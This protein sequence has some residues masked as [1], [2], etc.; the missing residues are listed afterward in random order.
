MSANEFHLM[1]TFHHRETIESTGNLSVSRAKRA[2]EKFEINEG[3]DFP[4]IA[5]QM[6]LS[7][8]LSV[9]KVYDK[10]TLISVGTISRSQ[11]YGAFINEKSLQIT[12]ATIELPYSRLN[13]SIHSFEVIKPYA[14]TLGSQGRLT[15]GKFIDHYFH[16]CSQLHINTASSIPSMNLSICRLLA[17]DKKAFYVPVESDWQTCIDKDH[18][19]KDDCTMVI[20]IPAEAIDILTLQITDDQ[21]TTNLDTIMTQFTAMTKSLTVDSRIVDLQTTKN[22]LVIIS[23]DCVTIANTKDMRVICKAKFEGQAL[24]C[25]IATSK[26][27]YCSMGNKIVALAMSRLRHLAEYISDMPEKRRNMFV[28]NS[29]Y[30]RCQFV[31]VLV[32]DEPSV[33]IMCH[34]RKMMWLVAEQ[35]IV[36][37]SNKRSFH[38]L[39]LKQT[40][41]IVICN[42]FKKSCYFDLIFK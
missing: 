23:I 11:T 18:M 41:R 13:N 2:C 8:H 38:A 1:H 25:S 5:D 15:F 35:K 12:N 32:D 34:V 19:P 37:G 24:D 10:T 3:G 28:I 14:I 20:R 6:K 36:V 39:Y 31:G 33:R 40:K 21:Q 7:D 30:G 17:S 16:Y 27:V 29:P 26:T 4:L 9:T 42:E 22:R